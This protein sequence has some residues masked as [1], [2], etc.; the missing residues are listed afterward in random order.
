MKKY[1]SPDLMPLIVLAAG[2]VGMLL[3]LWQYMGGTDGKGL[4]IRGHVS[5]VLLLILTCA[6][7]MESKSGQ[8]VP[9]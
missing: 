3:R 6:L 2:I 1:Y 5:T 7:H 9:L 4:L 8:Q